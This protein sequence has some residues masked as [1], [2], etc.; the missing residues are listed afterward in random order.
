M[1]PIETLEPFD[2]AQQFH[3]IV[4]RARLAPGG[5]ALN[6]IHAQDVGPPAGARIS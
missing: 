4:G 5:F 1:R 6:S 3:A 2:R